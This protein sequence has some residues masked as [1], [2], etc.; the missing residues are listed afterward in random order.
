MNASYV[1]RATND[2]LRSNVKFRV[3]CDVVK[4]YGNVCADTDAIHAAVKATLSAAKP[5]T[6][7]WSYSVTAKGEHFDNDLVT[8]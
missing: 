8:V 3:R 6:G 1:I 7:T 5:G 2:T 4:V